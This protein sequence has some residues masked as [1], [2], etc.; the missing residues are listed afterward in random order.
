MHPNLFCEGFLRNALIFE[1]RQQRLQ[2]HTLQVRL[3]VGEISD[4][5]SLLRLNNRKQAGILDER[6]GQGFAM[7]TGA[8]FANVTAT[9]GRETLGIKL[10]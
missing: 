1:L 9:G 3:H 5:L 4:V 8:V 10:D 6:D 2:G 7:V